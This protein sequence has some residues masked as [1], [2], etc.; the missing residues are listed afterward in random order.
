MVI[1]KLN[2]CCC[3]CSLRTGS[4]FIA[5]YSFISSLIFVSALIATITKFS[6]FNTTT[7]L[8]GPDIVQDSETQLIILI[9]I[10]ILLIITSF[11]LIIGTHKEYCCLMLPWIVIYIIVTVSEIIDLILEVVRMCFNTKDFEGLLAAGVQTYF[12]LVIYSYYREV[13][14]AAESGDGYLLQD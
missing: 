3:G 9:F 1:P 2:Y 12:L 10:N 5:W 13:K 7:S 8:S 6:A 11:I 4:K 14:N